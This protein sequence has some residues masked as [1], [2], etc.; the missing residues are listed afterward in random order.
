MFKILQIITGVL[1][2]SKFLDLFKG[3]EKLK[4]ELLNELLK[5][6]ERQNL[7]QI[8][9]N[10]NEALSKHW[11][12]A[13][14]RPFIGWVCGFALLYS[15]ILQPFFEFILL[16]FGMS[17]NAPELNI[18]QLISILFGM[19]GMATMRTYEKIKINKNNKNA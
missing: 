17:I 16:A 1:S 11:F 10:K 13:S 18:Q 3:K 6:V 5:N 19:L 4:N 2:D 15:F 12:V 14:W 7:A 9:V 8:E